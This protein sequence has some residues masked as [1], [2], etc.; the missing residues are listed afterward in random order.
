MNNNLTV[1]ASGLGTGVITSVS[2]VGINCPGTCVVLLPITQPPLQFSL[3]ATPD[4]GSYFVTWTAISIQQPGEVAPSISTLPF[5]IFDWSDTIPN[6]DFSVNARFELCPLI[7]LSSSTNF[8]YELGV[9]FDSGPATPT[10]GIGPYAYSIQPDYQCPGIPSC[11]G[12]TLPMGLTL[13]SSTGAISGI[14]TDTSNCTYIPISITDSK[15]CTSV[16]CIQLTLKPAP[17]G[18]CL[19]PCDGISEIFHVTNDLAQYVNKVIK[20]LDECF[21]VTIDNQGGCGSLKVLNNPIITAFDNCCECNPF[22]HYQLRDCSLQTPVIDTSTDLS[23]YVNQTIKVC[24]FS[25]DYLLSN[26]IQVPLACVGPNVLGF[27]TEITGSTSGFF[28]ENSTSLIKPYTN[29]SAFPLVIGSTVCFSSTY[30]VTGLGVDPTDTLQFF[31]GDVAITSIIPLSHAMTGVYL[32]YVINQSILDS[33]VL[34]GVLGFDGSGLH[35][36]LSYTGET[37]STSSTAIV[38]I[39]N[40]FPYITTSVL[41]GSCICY[42][43]VDLG[44]TCDILSSFTK[45][46]FGVFLDCECCNPPALPIPPPYIPIPPEINKHTYRIPDTQCDIDVT[47]KFANAMYEIYKAEAYGIESCCPKNLDNIWIA[48]ELLNLSKSK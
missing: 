11:L 15:G 13:N 43:V 20:I 47:V 42:N 18:Y 21:T 24:E 3:Q 30:V 41:S 7:G 5:Q 33:T 1:T 14:A 29:P 9:P 32:Q 46:I 22:K 38:T 40:Q 28:Y 2:P 37:T 48:K 16:V 27:V 45:P 10:A 25:A 6:V 39:P 26:Y 36:Q 4:T 8:E 31:I 34:L 23:Q 17:T 19:T 35:V 44:T 12:A